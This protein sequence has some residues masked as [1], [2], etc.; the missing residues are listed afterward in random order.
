MILRRTI[1]HFPV[2]DHVLGSVRAFS[3]PTEAPAPQA[4]DSG[5]VALERS[6]V[7]PT[8][9][10]SSA[11]NKLSYCC[12]GRSRHRPPR[13][14]PHLLHGVPA[15]RVACVSRRREETAGEPRQIARPLH[16]GTE[17]VGGREQTARRAS[18]AV[19]R[20]AGLAAG[21]SAPLPTP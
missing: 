15:T 6:A 10:T 17:Q 4:T 5:I 8:G 16:E 19:E 11:N 20:P 14:F 2:Y 7:D 21:R 3:S 1:V 13:D 12:W 18:A 9:P